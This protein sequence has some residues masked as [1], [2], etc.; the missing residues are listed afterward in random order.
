VRNFQAVLAEQP[1]YQDDGA[2]LREAERRR[3]LKT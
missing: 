3:D 2:R 1:D